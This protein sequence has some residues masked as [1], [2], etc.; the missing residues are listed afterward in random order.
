MNE[1]PFFD[2]NF[3]TERTMSSSVYEGRP[4][5]GGNHLMSPQYSNNLENNYS[6]THSPPSY[7]PEKINF[8][9]HSMSERN[10]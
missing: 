7:S 3:R 8:A 4:P 6:H 5:F 1:I 2:L 9:L 10:I